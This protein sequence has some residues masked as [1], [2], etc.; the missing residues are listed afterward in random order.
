MKTT[1]NRSA[2]LTA[3]GQSM[4]VLKGLNEPN[5]IKYDLGGGN[6][7]SGENILQVEKG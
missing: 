3:K 4:D 7:H 2:N 6:V 5:D 1:T